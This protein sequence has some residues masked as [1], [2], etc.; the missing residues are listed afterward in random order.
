M[1]ICLSNYIILNC[2][3]ME[4]KSVNPNSGEIIATYHEHTENEIKSILHDAGRAFEIWREVSIH[5]RSF[6]M[7]KAAAVLLENID[8]YSRTITIEMGKPIIESKA[9]IKKCAWVC[10]YYAQ[11]AEDFLA[12]EIIET[13]A[14][15]SFISYEPIG[16]V[17]AVMP[18][19][20]P[21]WQ[22]FRFAVPA[23]MAG[24]VGLLKHAS[25]VPGCAIKI[26]ELF[27]KA[28]FPKGVLQTL[29]INHDKVKEVIESDV[30]RAVALT[31]SDK[32]GA[33]VAS[34][35]GKSI[36][37]SVMELG[38]SNAFIVW[39]DADLD[40]TVET[41]LTARLQNTGQSCIAAKR[42]IIL[43]N[44]Y[45]GFLSKFTEGM[46]AFK[47]GDPLDENTRIG[48]LSREDLA[49]KLQEQVQKSV[50]QGAKVILGGKRKGA[51]FE[52][53]IMVNVKPGMPVFD[54][55]TFGPVAAIIKAK[56]EDEAFELAN[57]SPYGLG[58]SLF[59]RNVE[60]A[61]KCIRKISDGSFF[62]NEL[63]KSDP[64]LP[65]GGTKQSG[66]GRELSK[67]GILEFVNI[68]TVYIKY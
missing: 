44:V 31:G 24:N 21:F 18:W 19:N 37:K 1:I 64:R 16:C 11:N 4:F 58:I 48:P 68:K 45:E 27:E 10:N 46:K 6:L 51:F 12:N 34:I 65:F 36:K 14:Q 8:S 41:A 2:L 13:D 60:K 3:F 42:F 66:Y 26:Q 61:K 32:A 53:T 23:L 63:V 33:S 30:V 17:L 54:E 49:V 20:F 62:I 56:N 7:K 40:K 52:P 47:A 35:A 29:F 28:G 43:E 57:K 67:A 38:G 50:E 39:N 15:E 9:E 5:E 22:V 59:T 25:S 55:E